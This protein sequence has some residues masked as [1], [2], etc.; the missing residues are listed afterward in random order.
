MEIDEK[1]HIHKNTKWS[2]SVRK[3]GTEINITNGKYTLFLGEAFKGIE[4]SQEKADEL[5]KDAVAMCNLL[6]KEY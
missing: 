6:N 1:V 2:T 4:F 3:H 5:V